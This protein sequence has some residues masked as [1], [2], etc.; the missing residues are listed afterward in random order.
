MSVNQLK[1]LTVE[2]ASLNLRCESLRSNSFQSYGVNAVSV[3]LINQPGTITTTVDCSVGGTVR[4]KAVV[5]ITTNSSVAAGGTAT[6][7]TVQN[8]LI[9]TNSIVKAVVV[10]R[11]NGVNGTNGLPF[12]QAHT[13]SAGQCIID[14]CNC[15]NTAFAGYFKVLLEISVRV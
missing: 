11:V 9:T 3:Q 8:S 10:D 4:P 5:L 6:S 2:D 13:V 15:G 12:S 1:Q 7:F 14:I